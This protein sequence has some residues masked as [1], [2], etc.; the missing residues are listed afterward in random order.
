M[1]QRDRERQAIDAP[2]E[3]TGRRRAGVEMAHA[4]ADRARDLGYRVR[5]V[6]E[7][8]AWLLRERVVW[9]AQ[10]G[11]EA[12]GPRG[13]IGVFGGGGIA[14]A[15]VVAALLIASG[16]GSGSGGG[17]TEAFVI[18]ERGPVPTAV[19]PAPAPKKQKPAKPTGPTL[20]GAPPDFSAAQNVQSGVGD[21]KAVGK[22]AVSGGT[23][24]V[25]AEQGAGDKASSGPASAS[26]S[27][28]P[29]STAKIG[30]TPAATASA[31]AQ[32]DSL[33][34][35]AASGAAGAGANGTGTATGAK[36]AGA[37]GAEDESA[38][39]GPP[40]P[41]AAKRVARHFAEAFV[42]YETGGVDAKVRNGFRRTTTKQLSQALLH[43]P[44][45]QPANVKVPRAKVV[46]VVAGPSKGS[47]YE[48]SVSL[49]RVGVTSELRLQME[50]GPH[51]K[52]QVTNV[53]G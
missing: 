44:P 36:G 29:A 22:E 49:L 5:G 41:K 46:T 8:S 34:N 9:P 23:G 47:V 4:G 14:V 40:A 35:D 21:G 24:G 53:L 16:G 33:S 43:R 37:N 52:W 26:A 10:D 51:K 20:H 39:T 15:G 18:P 6:G 2:T 1:D 25:M 11:L 28:A 3:G 38:L 13:Q 32:A 17:A 12:L 48:V 50:Q 27:D 19:T 31:E 45:R 30:S 42:V 7:D